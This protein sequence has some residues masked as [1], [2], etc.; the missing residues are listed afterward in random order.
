MVF[1]GYPLLDNIQLTQYVSNVSAEVHFRFEFCE[2][3]L[4]ARDGIHGNR[5]SFERN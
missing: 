1:I 5:E 2:R 3:S 4:D